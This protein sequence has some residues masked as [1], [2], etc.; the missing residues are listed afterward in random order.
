MGLEVALGGAL[1]SL[2]VQFGVESQLMWQEGTVLDVVTVRFAV[3][4]LEVVVLEMARI[5]VE[6]AGLARQAV[7]LGVLR[8]LANVYLEVLSIQ[9]RHRCM[10]PLSIGELEL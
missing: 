1:T 10:R 7:D 3:V 6:D 5:L 8:Q 4:V 9:G 2:G